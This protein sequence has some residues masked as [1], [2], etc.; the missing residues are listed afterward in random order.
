[1][2]TVAL[3]IRTWTLALSVSILFILA[4]NLVLPFVPAHLA[5]NARLAPF[6]NWVNIGA[7]Q[8]LPTWYSSFMLLVCSVLTWLS[9]LTA[10]AET[11]RRNWHWLVLAAGFL[12]MAVDEAISIHEYF[13][14]IFIPYVKTEGFFAYAWVVVAIPLVVGLAVAFIPFLFRLPRRSAARF[15]IAGV[16]YVGGALVLEMIGSKVADGDMS[17]FL[18]HYVATV[19]EGLEMFGQLLMARAL[20]LHLVESPTKGEIRLS[21]S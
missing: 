18:T 13:S 1:M 15:L 17:G 7:E 4:V 12:F 2:T 16:V 11:G 19:E 5:A 9:A 20:L 3:R 14:V 6:L 10:K 21:I 8:S